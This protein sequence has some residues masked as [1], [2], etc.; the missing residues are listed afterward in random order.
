MSRK[1]SFTDRLI[2]QL[3]QGL[4][5]LFGQPDVTERANPTATVP[6]AELNHEERTLA[7]RLM[8][9]NHTGEVC[10][11][12]LYQGQALTARLHGVREQM[13]RAAREENDHLAWCEQ[14]L[15]ELGSHTSLLNPAFFAGSFAIGA[16]A[17]VAGDRWSLGFVA[18]TE[19]QVV[20]HLQDHLHRLPSHDDRSRAIVEQM[21][22]DEAKHASHAEE[23]GGTRLPLPIRL[24][25]K[26]T[27]KIMTGTTYWV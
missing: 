17:G 8:R 23:A 24:G 5:T 4:R 26:A 6:E 20:S 9:V 27:A 25:M 22:N 19:N 21:K 18:E 7:S 10:A 12:A 14:R 13:E 16:V 1:L 2:S 15:Q 11:Q 3:D